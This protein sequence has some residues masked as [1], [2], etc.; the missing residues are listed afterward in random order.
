[1]HELL[2]NLGLIS[3]TATA[4]YIIFWFDR[5]N[6]PRDFH[7]VRNHLQRITHPHLTIKG[8]GD[9]YIDYIDGDRQVL[10]YFKYMSLYRKNLE[11]MKKTSSIKILDHG[12]IS[13]KAW[14]KW[15][16]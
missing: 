12:L 4:F 2:Y 5:R 16:L 10:E 13:N 9:Y 3:L 1:M 8:H 15:G 11:E 7:L 14:E 6:T